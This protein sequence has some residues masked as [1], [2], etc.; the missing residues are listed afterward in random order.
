MSNVVLEKQEVNPRA[1]LVTILGQERVFTAA[2]VMEQNG[3]GCL[4][5]VDPQGRLA[6]V[7]SERDILRW[8]SNASPSSFDARV[9]SIMTSEVVSIA[10]GR[11]T[12]E[13]LRLMLAHR[14][15]HLLIVEHGLPVGMISMRDVA[16]D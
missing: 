10:P 4:A 1:R 16:G 3:V 8:V 9:T 14:V 2:K 6:G 12:A 5:V 13:A 7:V 15:R 11:P